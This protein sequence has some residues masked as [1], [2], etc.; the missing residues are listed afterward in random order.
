[1]SVALERGSDVPLAIFGLCCACASVNGKETIPGEVRYKP[2]ARYS[3]RPV[4]RGFS[5]SWARRGELC[6]R[7]SDAVGVPGNKNGILQ[8]SFP[9]NSLRKKSVGREGI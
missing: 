2:V 9:S 3:S 5:E 1:M 7:M 6:G 8:M 4:L